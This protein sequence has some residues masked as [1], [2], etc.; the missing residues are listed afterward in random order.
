M[1]HIYPKSLVRRAW[2][3]WLQNIPYLDD[4]NFHLLVF[5]GRFV[6][7]NV[8][9]Y[10]YCQGYYCKEYY[11]DPHEREEGS[12]VKPAAERGAVSYHDKMGWLVTMATYGYRSNHENNGT[13]GWR[14]EWF[15]NGTNGKI[16][17]NDLH[18]NNLL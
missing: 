15:G 10:Q 18:G 3:P 12:A 8:A 6:Q 13:G 5:V 9:L 1:D 16:I 7:L 2:L 11:R 4:L 17:S 14:P